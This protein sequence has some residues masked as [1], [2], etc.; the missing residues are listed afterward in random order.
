MDNSTNETNF[1]IF[2]K[3]DAGPFTLI[4]TTP[5]ANIKSYSDSTAANNTTTRSYSYYIKACNASGCSA[6]TKT[7]VVPFKPATLT[8]TAA[9]ATKV[10]LKWTDKS[11]NETGISC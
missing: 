8:A 10:N 7:A 5:K 11:S 6:Q 4:Y 9:S 3:R 2:R 1:K